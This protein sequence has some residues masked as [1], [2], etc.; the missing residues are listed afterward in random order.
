MRPGADVVRRTPLVSRTAVVLLLVLLAGCARS[1][2][3]DAAAT[4]NQVPLSKSLLKVLLAAQIFDPNQPTG[5]PSPDQYAQVEE[6]QRNTLSQLVRDQVMEQEARKLGVVVSDADVDARFAQFAQQF[7]G[8]D[9]FRAEIVKRGRSEGDVR[10]QIASIIRR[11][12]LSD[13][14]GRQA[15][16]TD[17]DVRAAYN[18]QLN[19]RFRL[20]STAHILVD[21]RQEADQLL[22]QLR[23]GANFAQLARERS[24]DRTTAP[25]GGE[26]GE[27]PRGQ[28]VKEFDDAVWSVRP[29]EVAGP[30]Q[31][32]FG[33]HLILVKSV[34]TIPFDQ[35]ASGLRSQLESQAGQKA[36]DDWFR[37][38]VSEADVWVDRRFGDWDPQAGLVKPHGSF[39]PEAGSG[40]AGA[41]PGSNTEPD[42]PE[43]GGP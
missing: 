1:Q 11:D 42:Q 41:G 6:A 28:F 2:P 21:T 26:L 7:G 43:R 14:F 32:R 22:A 16:V 17:A 23:A 27:Y 31:T 36:F 18:Q 40:A 29:G 19:T 37:K 15:R 20:A 5:L 12:A 13:Y 38:V 4:V 34:R 39:L 25:G 24:K 8:L 10:S 30:V 9:A 35:V 3:F 33:W